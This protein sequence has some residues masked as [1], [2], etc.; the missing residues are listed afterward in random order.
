MVKMKLGKYQHYKG[1]TYEV[2]ALGKHSETLEELV[3]YKNNDSEVWVRPKT[4]F[5]ET[6]E[7]E[8]KVIPR[9]KYLQE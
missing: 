6:I 2:I 4:M 1:N 8:G 7:R 3:I 5:L 9:F